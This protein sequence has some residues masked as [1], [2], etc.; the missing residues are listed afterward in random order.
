MSVHERSVKRVSCVRRP[1]HVAVMGTWNWLE[2]AAELLRRAG[3][4]CETIP[5]LPNRRAFMKWVLRGEWRRFDAIH[6]VRGTIWSSGLTF[7]VL[8]KP[9]V[10][11]WIGTDALRFQ[12]IHRC[13][14][15]WRGALSRRLVR[16][17][18]LAHLADSPELA[19]ELDTYGIR[20][21]VVRLLP[22]AIEAQ[23]ESLPEKPCVLSYWAPI[24]RKF[25]CGPVVMK[26]AESF[27]EIPFLIV[28]DDGKG[29]K[30]PKNVQSSITRK[31]CVVDAV[32]IACVLSPL[33]KFWNT[34][35]RI[36]V[37][38]QVAAMLMQPNNSAVLTVSVKS[39]SSIVT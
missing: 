24:S 2:V 11:H 15:S 31:S 7:A 32:F 22:K 12:S 13:G 37:Q 29:M 28:G 34:H 23:V 39:Q 21:E 20:A 17:W 9:V 33:S 8:G 38:S 36:V 26:L 35:P 4:T 18:S 1:F 27:P 5:D 19:A 6:H 25:Y 3:I 30:S 10:W 16:Q 14:G